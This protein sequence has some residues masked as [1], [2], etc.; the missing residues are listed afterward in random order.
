MNSTRKQKVLD[1]RKDP[2]LSFSTLCDQWFGYS[3]CR[4]NRTHLEHPR[5]QISR[6]S[7]LTLRWNVLSHWFAL[8]FLHSI[9]LIFGDGVFSFVQKLL[10]QRHK[11]LGWVG[12]RPISFSLPC[13][14]LPVISRNFL[15]S[16]HHY[17]PPKM[18]GVCNISKS[19]LKT[20][21]VNIQTSETA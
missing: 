1:G 14:L 8:S 18:T 21:Y 2:Y 3:K 12:R 20:R 11:R 19:V 13:I 4:K 6:Q 17:H 15:W 16:R 5:N 7:L 10:W 9:R